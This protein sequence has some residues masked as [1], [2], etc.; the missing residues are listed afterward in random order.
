MSND[1]PTVTEP[2]TVSVDQ[3]PER[4]EHGWPNGATAERPEPSSE[5]PWHARAVDGA[6]FVLDQPATVPAVWG[7][8]ERVLWAEGEALMLCGP[9]GV[10]KTTLA[11]QV[12]AA[13][14]G[15]LD[16]VLGMPVTAGGGR[17]VLL[18]CDRPSQIARSLRRT[19]RPEWRQVLAQR[20]VVWKGPPPADFAQYP[21]W[22]AAMA[23]RYEADTLVVDSIKDVALGISDDAVGAGYNR[24]RQATLVGG[25]QVLELHHQV[26]RGAN[27]GP[28]TTLADVYGSVWLTAGAG[29]VVLLWG[30]AGDPVVRLTHL[31]Q[32]ATEVGPFDVLH[33]HH[34][35]LSTV[36]GEPDLVALAG[37][38]PAGLTAPEAAAVLF[39]TAKPTR[40]QVEKARRRLDREVAAGWLVFGS[41]RAGGVDGGSPTTYHAAAR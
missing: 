22:M 5:P 32:P 14:L 30:E 34:A 28:P 40:A 33:D 21:Q 26:K 3:L 9:S 41:G 31:K 29:S 27:G 1:W 8:G 36:Q 7:N 25:V 11:G 20:L 15:L 4:V 18:A 2:G 19:M 12:M 39:A 23:K 10:G 37:A 13:R 24:A 35:G 16:S 6:A 17:V 38:K